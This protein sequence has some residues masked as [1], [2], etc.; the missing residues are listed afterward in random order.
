M[1]DIHKLIHGIERALIGISVRGSQPRAAFDPVRCCAAMPWPA[2]SYGAGPGQPPAET[3]LLS[4]SLGEMG[5]AQ[6]GV[7]QARCSVLHEQAQ[8]FFDGLQIGG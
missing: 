1:Q 6:P 5:V 8:D 3:S 4:L 2:C 7:H